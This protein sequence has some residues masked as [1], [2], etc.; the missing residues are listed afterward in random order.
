MSYRTQ[1][2]R[3]EYEGRKMM[4]EH[5]AAAVIAKCIAGGFAC[6]V[7]AIAIASTVRAT[8]R[9]N[10]DVAIQA[11]KAAE[12]KAHSDQAMFDSMKRKGE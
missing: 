2:T 4:N 6:L 11:S 1:A 7:F 12:A 5:E 9:D 3:D 8:H 10:A